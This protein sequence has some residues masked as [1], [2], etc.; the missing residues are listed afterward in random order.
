MV[1][2]LKADFPAVV[3]GL[4]SLMI[5]ESNCGALGVEGVDSK[6]SFC[7]TSEGPLVRFRVIEGPDGM[8]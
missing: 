5:D 3:M 7:Q 8:G 2:T 6:P 4:A 1:N